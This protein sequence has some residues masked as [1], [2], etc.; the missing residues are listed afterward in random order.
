MTSLE[1]RK[2][3][4]LAFSGV[5][6]NKEIQEAVMDASINCPKLFQLLVTGTQGS[7]LDHRLINPITTLVCR[8]SVLRFWRYDDFA[9]DY[10][11]GQQFTYEYEIL[12]SAHEKDCKHIVPLQDVRLTRYAA[13]F[14]YNVYDM[15]LRMYLRKH[16]DHRKLNE[17]LLQVVAG[18]K[19]LHNLGYVHRDLKP[20][21]IVINIKPPMKV[22][23]IDFD[24]SLLKTMT[25]KNGVRGTPGYQWDNAPW[26]DGDYLWDVY[27]LTVII[28]EFDMPKDEYFRIKDER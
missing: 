2:E 21:N 19:E 16:R 27:A 25:C 13:V 26:V 23:L 6:A 7:D 9:L 5:K 1:E 8:D 3:T 22:V 12:T 11:L 28:A 10:M 15:D 18:L 17:I 20:E 4:R 24:R 14:N